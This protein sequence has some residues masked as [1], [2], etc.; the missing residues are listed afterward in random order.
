M[1][2]CDLAPDKLSSLISYP[3]LTQLQSHLASLLCSKNTEL[4]PSLG[5]FHWQ[6]LLLE[7]LSLHHL[8]ASF[9]VI[10]VTN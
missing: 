6:F 8:V 9:F 10:Q 1:A 2:P 3:N 4:L 7:A 5:P